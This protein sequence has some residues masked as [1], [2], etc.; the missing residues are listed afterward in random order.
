LRDVETKTLMAPPHR[1]SSGHRRPATVIC[2]PPTRI[3]TL[4]TPYRPGRR[5]L[6]DGRCAPKHPS[7]T[8][9]FLFLVSLGFVLMSNAEHGFCDKKKTALIPV[10]QRRSLC[11]MPVLNGVPG[12]EGGWFYL[13]LLP[14]RAP[15]ENV[16][17]AGGAG[18]LRRA[19]ACW[20]SVRQPIGA[21]Q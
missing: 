5:I 4:A 17:G 12:K 1:K 10:F 3:R 20:A 11:L 19:A 15:L 14:V 8:F 13:S 9:R 6:E 21:K 7:T 2:F 16:I 18:C